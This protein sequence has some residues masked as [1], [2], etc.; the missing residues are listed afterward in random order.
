MT[1]GL[2]D[3][4]VS[5]AQ[6]RAAIQALISHIRKSTSQS[7]KLELL[8]PKED[9]VWLVLATKRMHP[10]A[11]LKPCKIPLAHSL[12]D[13][14][15][16]SIC[17][18]TKDPQRQYKDLLAAK[19]VDFVSRVVGVEKLKGKYKPF[20]TRRQLLRESGLFLADERVVP[21]LP[22]LLGKMFFE[23]KKQPIPVC[24]TKRD[25]KGELE[26]AISSTYMHQN[27]GTCTSIKIALSSE[28]AQHMV[29]NLVI[30]LPVIVTNTPGGWENVQSLHIKTSQS[31]SLPIW[32][33]DL[34]VG[35]RSTNIDDPT[36]GADG[37]KDTKHNATPR[38]APSR[39]SSSPATNKTTLTTST[40]PSQDAIVPI[41]LSI[42]E[43]KLKRIRRLEAK[44]EMVAKGKTKL[45]GRGVK[46]SVLGKVPVA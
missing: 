36:P 44:K 23:A 10:V 20:E 39:P 45:L 46:G 37:T 42:A 14:K 31:V 1:E 24:L 8:G 21:L 28:T 35:M 34:G 19:G 5:H 22:K 25:I 40:P 32:S 41:G 29:E 27:K 3:S 16:N 7:E 30:A 9:Y 18:I 11:K 15:D 6:A 26:G 38:T 12:V 13:P 43:L 17:L 2:I 4:H 33:C